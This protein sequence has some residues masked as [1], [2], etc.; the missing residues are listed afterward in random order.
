MYVSD[1]NLIYPNPLHFYTSYNIHI[2]NTHIQ[3][4]YITLFN[5]TYNMPSPGARNRTSNLYTKCLMIYYDFLLYAWVWMKYMSLANPHHIHLR[6]L[7]LI[8]FFITI[9]NHSHILSYYYHYH[10]YYLIFTILINIS[11][12]ELLQGVLV[13]LAPPVARSCLL[14]ALL[15]DLPP[16]FSSTKFSSSI[17]LS[18]LVC[19]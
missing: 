13:F 15:L 1:I 19:H 4:I 17:P 8:Y 7:I 6:L 3:L 2:Y 5:W 10:Y 18:L 16:S 14:P 11:I 12:Y 9:Y